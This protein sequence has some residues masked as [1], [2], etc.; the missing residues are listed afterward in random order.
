LSG[1]RA[2]SG[3]KQMA[4][5]DP[6]TTFVGAN[7]HHCEPLAAPRRCASRHDYRLLV[8][9]GA[10][11]EEFETPRKVTLGFRNI[12]WETFSEI[13]EVDQFN[14]E[15]EWLSEKWTLRSIWIGISVDVELTYS[16]DDKRNVFV[17]FELVSATGRDSSYINRATFSLGLNEQ[18]S[19]AALFEEI[20]KFGKCNSLLD[21]LSH[22]R[23]F[24]GRFIHT[25]K[26]EVTESVDFVCILLFY[27]YSLLFIW[28][29][30]RF[31]AAIKINAETHEALH[32]LSEV[33]RVRASII[34]VER[35]FLTTNVTN[36]PALKQNARD[37]RSSFAL[38]EKFDGYLALNESIEKY[39][40]TA[41]QLAS[42]RRS[43]RVTYFVFL[44]ALVSVPLALVQAL[45]SYNGSALFVQQGI[46]KPLLTIEF[47]R[48]IAGTVAI[49]LMLIV[50]GYILVSLS[51]TTI[52]RIEPILLRA[53]FPKKA[54][55]GNQKKRIFAGS[56][57]R[58][59]SENS[60]AKKSPPA[61]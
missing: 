7:F 56:P 33:L 17:F 51:S 16:L 6:V 20:C 57:P 29:I 58:A 23:D 47:L 10:V 22:D 31:Q 44:F 53:I 39:I 45:L 37:L 61:T 18:T 8:D 42:E 1:R 11:Q 38:R 2:M 50:I 12:F 40:A 60:A 25:P 28:Q 54:M 24:P 14:L 41:S 30:N 36:D 9:H 59:P 43:R 32:Q 34:N 27:S 35:Y 52:Q 46:L 48:F 13:L 26:H 5:I 19:M 3:E 15:I 4:S 49:Y 55:A 21:S